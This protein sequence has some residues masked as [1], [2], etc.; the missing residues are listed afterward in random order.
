YLTPGIF[1]DSE[2]PVV[3]SLA[4]YFQKKYSNQIDL[5]VAFF[6]YVRDSY[7]YSIV[8]DSY[9]NIIFKASYCLSNRTSFCIPKA[10]SLAALAR[11][12]GIPSRIHFADLKNQRI[13]EHLYKTLG[14]NIMYYHCYTELFLDDKWV[15]ATPSFDL[16]T[17]LRHNLPPV[18][19]DGY[20][21]GLFAPYDDE[22]NPYCQYINDRGYYDDVPIDIIIEGFSHYYG[23]VDTVF[24]K[25]RKE[26]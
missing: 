13:P 14:T 24:L 20:S 5:A 18:E 23:N 26:S 21:D 16:Q 2:S 7:K 1:I 15:K 4:E 22:G 19:F 3:K 9:D 8:F 6:Y 11:T 25:N 10:T 17:C 12:S